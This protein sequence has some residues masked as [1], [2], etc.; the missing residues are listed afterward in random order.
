MKKMSKRMRTIR[1]QIPQKPHFSVNEAVE[2]LKKVSSVQF[3]E[4][5]EVTVNLGVDPRKSEQVVRG[6]TTLPHGIGKSIRVAVFAQGAKA[7][8]AKQAGADVVG[9]EDLAEEIKKGRLDFDVII[10]T[11]DTMKIVGQL[12]KILGPKGL[13]PNPKVGTVTDE[14]ETA[15]QNAKAGQAHYRTD[16]NGIIH[17]ILGKLNFNGEQLSD[18][19][20]ALIADLKKAKP[21]TAKGVYIQKVTLASTMGPGLPV[22]LSTMN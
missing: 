12:G 8:T 11:P 17:C 5:V 21:S 9:Y 22:D 10:A 7:E 13:M 6:A 15:I 16:R 18:N 14:L 4:S 2:L 1:E 20:K 3:N 19:L